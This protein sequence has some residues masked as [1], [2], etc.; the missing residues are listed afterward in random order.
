VSVKGVVLLEGRVALLRN[1]RDEWELPGGKL[2]LGENPADCVQREVAEELGVAVETG[3]LLDTWLYHI[4]E[5]A[6]VLIVTYGCRPVGDTQP[7]HSAEHSALGLFDPADVPSLRMPDGYKASVARW[8]AHP[9]SGARPVFPGKR[10][11][12]GAV[13]RDVDR[14]ILLVK[15]TY[16]EDWSVPGG[17]IEEGEAPLV[18]CRR[19]VR[20]ELGLDLPIGRL[21]AV[22]YTAPDARIGDSLQFLFDGGVLGP[23]E[24]AHIR[25]PAGELSAFRFA[26]WPE[27]RRLLGSGKLARR[28]PTCLRALDEGRTL[29]LHD[30]DGPV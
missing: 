7:S 10:V 17:V 6:D 23:A 15:P 20:E 18:G 2:E 13:V 11:G 24:I 12:A 22:D 14:R 9:A 28:F 21:I 1:E 19:E 30:G 8:T 25:L 4:Y 26:P 5:G 29:Y 16:R 27:A 3:P